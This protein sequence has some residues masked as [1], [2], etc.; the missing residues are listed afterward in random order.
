MLAVIKK[1]LKTYFCML[2]YSNTKAQTLNT[3]FIQGQQ[4]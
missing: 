2:M 1:E 4:Y 3:Y